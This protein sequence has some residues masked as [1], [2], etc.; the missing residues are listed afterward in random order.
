MA[1]LPMKDKVTVHK[2]GTID[3]WGIMQFPGESFVIPGRIKHTLYMRDEE[4][5]FTTIKNDLNVRGSVL[6]EGI[7]DVTLN[8][9]LEFTNFRG[10]RERV[11]PNRAKFIQDFNGKVLFTRINF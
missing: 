9:E 4:G 5:T 2:A 10:E 11:K 3:D 7:V 8:D 1:M 6:F